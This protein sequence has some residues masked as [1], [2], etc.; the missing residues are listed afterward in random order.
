[1]DN[2]Y[3]YH[4]LLGESDI[5]ILHIYGSSHGVLFFQLFTVSLHD[6]P[7]FEAVSYTWGSNIRDRTITYKTVTRKVCYTLRRTVR[8][9]Y[10]AW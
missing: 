9:L 7:H 5:R 8:Q 10:A 2:R 6:I 4:P 1:M 3:R